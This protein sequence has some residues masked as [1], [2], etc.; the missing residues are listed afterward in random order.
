MKYCIISISEQRAENINEI[1]R[2]MSHAPENIKFCN[3]KSSL[4]RSYFRKKFPEFDFSKYAENP[5][6]YTDP[7]RKYG[8]IGCWMSHISSWDYMISNN[9]KEMIIFEDDCLFN[10]EL[11]EK[12]FKII[13]ENPDKNLL[14]LGQ[15]SEMYYIKLSAAR[16][17]FDNALEKGYNRCP[18]DEYMF[19]MI[20]E[21]EV[22]GMYGINA[23]KQLTHMY[24]SD[25]TFSIFEGNDA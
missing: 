16:K 7:S 24:P 20:K 4:D 19:N 1:V 13:K 10:K 15:W 14:M 23:V 12:T 9:I 21:S 2:A 5:L 22:D 17:L 25:M 18:V 8:A 11:E 3:M 6:Y